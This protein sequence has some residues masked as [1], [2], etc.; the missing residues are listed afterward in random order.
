MTLNQNSFEQSPM[1]SRAFR[2]NDFERQLENLSR[3]FEGEYGMKGLV[4]I[5]VTPEAWDALSKDVKASGL[6]V[7]PCNENDF[8]VGQV[9][10]TK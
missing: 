7:Y 4:E 3:F 6:L 2:F 9:L 10:I 5:K 8:R 1:K